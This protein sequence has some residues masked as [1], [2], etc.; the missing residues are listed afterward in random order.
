MDGEAKLREIEEA[1]HSYQTTVIPKEGG[2]QTQ[3]SSHKTMSPLLRRRL[4]HHS[5]VSRAV[6]GSNKR[7]YLEQGLGVLFFLDCWAASL[8]CLWWHTWNLDQLLTVSNEKEGGTDIK[9]L[10]GKR[11]VL[12]LRESP[13]P[14]G[15]E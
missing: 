12:Q 4:A 14:R 2:F 3:F 5:I 13:G 10:K 9:I 1:M 11:W 6:R 7:E 8:P 15:A